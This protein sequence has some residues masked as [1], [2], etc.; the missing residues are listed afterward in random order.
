MFIVVRCTLPLAP[1]ERHPARTD[2]AP[3]ELEMA[4]ASRFYKHCAPP[5]RGTR[6]LMSMIVGQARGIAVAIATAG[7]VC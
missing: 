6:R 4:V 2:A 7:Q 5:E 3:P 1:E